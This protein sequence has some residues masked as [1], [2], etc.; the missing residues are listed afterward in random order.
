MTTN[1]LSDSYYYL[2]KKQIII[3]I[4]KN[5]R[6]IG[7]MYKN[8][9]IFKIE[10]NHI[11]PEKGKILISEP[12]LCDEV[13]GR[14]VI[15]LID[16]TFRGTM[17]LILNKPLPLSLDN[18]LGNIN[19][20]EQIPIYRGGPLCMDTLFFLH[21]LGQIPDSLPISQGFY[22]NGNFEA[23][24]LYITSGNSVEGKIR[25]FL[26]Y[27]GWSYNQLYHEINGN[28][29]MVGNE[30]PSTL[31][32]VHNKNLWKDALCKLGNKYKLWAHFP[33]K[34]HYN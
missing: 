10:T 9:N 26:G 3:A 12:F 28:T 24:K 31:M 2:K 7:G 25:F 21:T 11:V 32:N 34:P 15:L 30:P 6:I 5:N 27:S 17:G 20:Q 23:I 1:N 33:I 13:F 19:L 4:Y 18:L 22:L 8:T 29:W 16:H 14:S